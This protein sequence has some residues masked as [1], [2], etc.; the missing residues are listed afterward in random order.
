M[1]A[2]VAEAI[3]PVESATTY[4][5]GVAVPVNVANGSKVTTPVCGSTV[6]VPSFTTNREVEVQLISSVP[7]GHSRI[8]LGLRKAP[9]PAVSPTRTLI[10]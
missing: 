6:Y 3:C 8:E 1:T 5:I 7:V 4:L 10:V 9:A 2:I